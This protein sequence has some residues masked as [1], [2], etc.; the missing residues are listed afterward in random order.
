MGRTFSVS[1]VCGLILLSLVESKISTQQGTH[2]D[3]SLAL[4]WSWLSLA[5]LLQEKSRY[6]TRFDLSCPDM[7]NMYKHPHGACSCSLCLSHPAAWLKILLWWWNGKGIDTWVERAQKKWGRGSHSS[8]ILLRML[9]N[10]GPLTLPAEGTVEDQEVCHC[11][12]SYKALPMLTQL[13]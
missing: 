7:V 9:W 13:C 3:N 5:A 11:F 12:S 10:R 4:L 6:S 1:F 8:H 2:K